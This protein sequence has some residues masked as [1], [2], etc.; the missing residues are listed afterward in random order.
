MLPG[1]MMASRLVRLRFRPLRFVSPDGI[2]RFI[3]TTT[4]F[5]TPV[6]NTLSELALESFFPADAATAETLR[7]L[8]DERQQ[9]EGVERA[10][11]A[12]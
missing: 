10:K 9:V 2:L 5:G 1:G 3:S 11:R 12:A 8:A 7:R 6:D 4:V